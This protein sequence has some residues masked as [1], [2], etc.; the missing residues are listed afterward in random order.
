MAIWFLKIVIRKVA[1]KI[2]NFLHNVYQEIK[3]G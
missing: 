3:Y 2:K 1:C